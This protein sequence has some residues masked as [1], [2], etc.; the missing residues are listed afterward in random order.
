MPGGFE[1]V[2]EQIVERLTLRRRGRP[3]VHVPAEQDLRAL[4][5]LRLYVRIGVQHRY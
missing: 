2:A 1:I 4:A 5:V 3:P